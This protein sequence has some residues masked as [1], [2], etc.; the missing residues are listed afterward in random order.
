MTIAE[1]QQQLEAAVPSASPAVKK[2]LIWLS[3]HTPELA[4]KQVESAAKAADVS[5]ASIVR[6]VQLA[7]FQGFLDVQAQVRAHEPVIPV[8]W[9]TLQQRQQQMAMD[10]VGL[11]VAQEI[12]NLEQLGSYIRPQLSDWVDWL[13][14]RR[15][16]VVTATLMTASLA[17]YLGLLLRYLLGGVDFVDASSGQAWLRLR[18]I[19]EDDG[20]IGVSYPRYAKRTATFLER[21]RDYTT[22]TAF[23]TDLGG[24]T[25]PVERMLRLPSVSRA[26]HS[27]AVALIAFVDMLANE[28]AEREPDRVRH[29]LEEADRLWLA[30][31]DSE[32]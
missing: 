25:L 8:A 30:L 23:I 15:R 13:L 20:V 4:W 29:N 27:S 12:A 3:Q 22:H 31:N 6:A 11:V 17:E 32:R 26:H 28:M 1:I 14:S 18:D 2:A 24:P 9:Q 21:C 10:T 19:S 5:P 16:I 7:G